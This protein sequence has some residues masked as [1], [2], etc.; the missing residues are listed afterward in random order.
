MIKILYKSENALI[1][2]KPAGV[3]SQSD[4]SGDDDIM[5]L[6]SSQLSALGESGQ[7]YL[8]NRLDRVVGGLMLLARTKAAA[9]SL[10]S[11]VSGE[12]VGK[13]YYA[14]LEGALSSSGLSPEGELVDHLFKDSRFSRA[15]I[16]QK[17]RAGAKE[18][19]L[20]YKA[21]A[22]EHLGDRCYTLISVKLVSG[23]FH[24]IRA[25][26]SH[27]ALPIAG[28]RK[29]GAADR[30][31]AFPALYSHKISVMLGK[32]RIGAESPPPLDEHPWSLF[33]KYLGESE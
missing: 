10:S 23:R 2:Q 30:S 22:Q 18:A 19:R 33:K 11:L 7:L 6:L 3:P 20:R 31:A 12:G 32:E 14:V 13:E 24:Q 27:R 25:Q 28:D 16:C 1:A 15:V 17:G 26:F 21:L 29:Y 4:K 8:I 9:A 5:T